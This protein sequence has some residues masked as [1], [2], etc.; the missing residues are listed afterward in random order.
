MF[1]RIKAARKNCGFSELDA[2]LVALGRERRQPR[3]GGSHYVYR[4]AGCQPITVPRAKTI[5]ETY[6][7]QVLEW[8]EEEIA[9]L[10]EAEK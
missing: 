2:L 10:R 5:K 1:D 7:K 3:R 9:I 4:K 8:A 6:V